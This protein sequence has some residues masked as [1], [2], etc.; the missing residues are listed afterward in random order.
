DSADRWLAKAEALAP[1]NPWVAVERAGI[2][3][4]ED[5]YEEAL[6]SA[7]RA[8]ALRPWYRPGVQAAAGA[9]QNLS[10][11]RDALDL[12]LEADRQIESG[13]IVLQILGLQTE[14]TL[15]DDAAG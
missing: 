14:L 5:R 1:E 3:E 12:L 4:M 7:N 10:R 9:L 13:A 15:Y 11:E 2:L 8:L 6:E